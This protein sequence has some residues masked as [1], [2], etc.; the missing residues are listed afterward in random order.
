M[1]GRERMTPMIRRAVLVSRLFSTLSFFGLLLCS[2]EEVFSQTAPANNH[3]K[4]YDTE[5]K[6]VADPAVLLRDQF[7]PAGAL[8]E[9]KVFKAIRFCNPAAKTTE[10]GFVTPIADPFLHL[11]LYLTAP[12]ELAPTRR[13]V[14]RNQFGQQRLHV[15]SPIILA[16]PTRKNDMPASNNNDHYKCYSASGRSLRLGVELEDQFTEGDP[17]PA[18]VFR[19]RLFCNPTEKRHGTVIAPI[20]NPQNHL[21]CYTMQTKDLSAEARVANQFETEPLTFA[22]PD[23]LCVPTA[24]IRVSVIQ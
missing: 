12:T 10:D 22:R 1:K 14:V 13:V 3:F 23:L 15:Y 4:C 11:T 5:G 7:D 16:V 8:K 21:L 6:Q 17:Q 24:K 2:P 18:R 19:P 20:Q 9:T